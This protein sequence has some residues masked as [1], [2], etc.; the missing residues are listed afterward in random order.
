MLEHKDSDREGERDSSEQTYFDRV[1]E[2]R[3]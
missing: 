3:T 2:I 1:R